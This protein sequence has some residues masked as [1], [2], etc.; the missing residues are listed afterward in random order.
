MPVAGVSIEWDDQS[1]IPEIDT[2]PPK[3]N[4][5]RPIFMTAITSDKGPEDWNHKV[6]GSDFFRL[7]GEPSFSR[8]GQA[9]IQAAQIINKGGYLTVKR[10]VADDAKLAN[11]VLMASV[12][13]ITDLQ[14]VDSAGVPVWYYQ[15]PNSENNDPI[16]IS[17]S[18]EPVPG[19]G[20]IPAN[21]TISRSLVDGVQVRYYFRSYALAS[22]N[23]INAYVDAARNVYDS[24]GAPALG[25]DG[26]YPL[27]VITEM[28]RGVSN[29]RFRIYADTTASSP[30]TYFRYFF[31]LSE[32]GSIIE[33]IPFTFNPDINE[34]PT[35]NGTPQNMSLQ[36]SIFRN[37]T[38]VRARF[39]DDI[40]DDFISNL[41]FFTG[42]NNLRFKDVLFANDSYGR[43]IYNFQ[44]N[45]TPDLDSLYGVPL[46]GG[47]N[48]EFGTAPA[49]IPRVNGMNC[50]DVA[51]KNAF[52]GNTYD[53][54][55]IYDL[56]NNRIDV[57]FDAN[58][59]QEVKRAI[60]QL[61]NFREDCMFF[62]DFG[63]QITNIPQMRIVASYG[64][65]SRF[66]AD[67]VNSY[68]IYDPFTR[69]QI[70]VTVTYDLAQLF[71]SHFLNGRARPFC[72]QKYGIVIPQGDFITGSLNIA[73][74]RTPSED[75]R[76]IFDTLRIN[77]LTYY[78]GNILTMN[79]E[80]TSQTIY[81][82]LSWL[83]NVLAVQEMIKAIRVICPRIR[84]SFLDGD[85]LVQYRKDVQSFVIDKYSNRF[86]TCE[87]DYATN[88]AYDSNKIIYAVIRLRF[89]N[90]VQ[91]EMF[92]IIAL[93]S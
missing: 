87:I 38:Q 31:E 89:R 54:D 2:S 84:Y 25:M 86:Q 3:D 92:K 76:K 21:V 23:N 91:T 4:L 30:V 7:Y 41:E 74:R 8:H 79:T 43:S 40:Y 19:E 85:D 88:A 18:T 26:E 56:D 66:I 50:V 15:D 33:T 9:S 14:E 28:G 42:Q 58:Y 16:Y 80:Y 44:T 59:A 78:D 77:Y 10:V 65:K 20:T 61:V 47:D 55:D 81:T 45:G 37:S 11:V 82:Q 69:K 49:R 39:F 60:E 32:N 51:L 62:R 34:T 73:P 57:I 71:I 22:T 29:K 6:F 12:K 48:G 75:Q 5:D 53:G 35:T 17:S 72:G 52:S 68:K 90:F 93:Q 46:V 83:N 70:D 36:N 13:K 63:T 27:A 64:S 1:F 67:Y 24:Q